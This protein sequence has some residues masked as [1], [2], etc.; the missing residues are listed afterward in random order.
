VLYHM[1]LRAVT[2]GTCKCQ[3]AFVSMTLMTEGGGSE[4][5]T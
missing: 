2:A 3:F 1:V 5:S 4:V